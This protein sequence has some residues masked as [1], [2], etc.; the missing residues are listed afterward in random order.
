MSRIV[1][2]PVLHAQLIEEALA[3]L[4]AQDWKRAATLWRELYRLGALTCTE[5]FHAC[6]RALEAVQDWALHE[7]V[8]AEAVLLFPEN[9]ELVSRVSYRQAMQIYADARWREAFELLHHLERRK[10][11][12]WAFPV[13]YYRWQAFIQSL[14]ELDGAPERRLQQVVQQAFFKHPCLFSRQLAGLDLVIDCMGWSDE[15]V[16][17]F[18]QHLALLVSVLAQTD[19][20]LSTVIGPWSLPSVQGVANFFRAEPQLLVSLPRPYVHFLARLFLLHGFYDLYR[21]FRADFVEKTAR[22]TIPPSHDSCLPEFFFAVAFQS[23][24]G[25]EAGMQALTA[26][27]S[28]RKVGERA[29]AERI[30]TLSELYFPRRP[31][32]EYPRMHEDTEFA[33]LIHGKSIAVVGPVDVGLDNGREIDGFDLVIRFNPRPSV[34]L[35]SERFGQR[36]DIGYYS[37]INLM[38]GCAEYLD[39]MNALLWVV[40]EERNRPDVRWLDNVCTPVREHLRGWGYESPFLFGAP[41][42][43][44]RVLM[45][46]LRFQPARLKVFNSNFYVTANFAGGYRDCQMNMFP[47]L[48]IHDPVSNFLFTRQCLRNW[49]VE[50]DSVVGEVLSLEVDDY[51]DHLGR[52]YARF[53]R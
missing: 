12:S 46:V 26:Q 24:N 1:E 14:L 29:A 42:A 23:E 52:Q 31:Q 7:Q 39:A 35:A 50:A 17:E 32:G 18:R 37:T 10:P 15:L 45:D 9:S 2:T 43:V 25:D 53:A 16:F 33:E 5:D 51:M 40:V 21:R 28:E 47:A 20:N 8:L 22:A 4:Q 27:V 44:Q 3:G 48:A 11:S 19:R 34:V 36:T 38:N 49:N 30:V 6:A 13:G 41:N